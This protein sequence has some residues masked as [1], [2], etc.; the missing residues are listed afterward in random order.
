MTFNTPNYTLRVQTND[1]VYYTNANFNFY[2]RVSL[3]D[4]EILNPDNCV[5]WQS[6]P[7]N[8][9]SC[10][11]GDFS[12]AS[13][14]DV[15]YNVYTPVIYI[16]M[17]RFTESGSINP[18]VGSTCGY[19]VTYSVKWRNFFDTTIP[20]PPWI[21]WKPT[22]FRYEVYTNDPK[23]INHTRQIYKLELTASIASTD[24]NP[25]LTKTQ[26]VNLIV[27]NQCTNDEMT[28]T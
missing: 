24:M 1:P 18:K 2:L 28:I 13:I 11:I 25:V 19:T 21:V 17:V 4:Y 7:L 26:T 9:K 23:D 10:R 3:S 12:F 16:N 20:L 27:D 22:E 14:A 15:T 8:L 5:R 6:I